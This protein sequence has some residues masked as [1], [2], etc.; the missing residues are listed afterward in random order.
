MATN[1]VNSLCVRVCIP[2]KSDV[3]INREF[4]DSVQQLCTVD[5]EI[6]MLKIICVKNFRIVKFSRFRSIREIFCNG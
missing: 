6:F 4:V 5:W 3:Q 2:R 1:T